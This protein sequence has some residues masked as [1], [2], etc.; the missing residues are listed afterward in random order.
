MKAAIYARVSTEDQTHNYS[1]PTQIEACQ[2]AAEELGYSIVRENTFIDDG[3]SGATLDRPN[4]ERL[5]TAIEQGSIQAVICYDTDRLS[6]KL[7]HL[8][9]LTEEWDRRNIATTINEFQAEVVKHVF[10]WFLQEDLSTREIAQRLVEKGIP[11]STGLR[12]WHRGTVAE[13]LKD[14]TYAGTMYHNKRHSKT[15]P[16]GRKRSFILRPEA[17]WIGVPV[18]DI[19]PKEWVDLAVAK[20]EQHKHRIRRKSEHQYLLSGMGILTCACGGAITGRAR[21]RKSGKYYRWYDCNNSHLAFWP[22]E[23]RC[24]VRDLNADLAD[25]A[26]WGKIRD[27]LLN[28]DLIV[29]E[30]QRRYERKDEDLNSLRE[31]LDFVGQRLAKIDE[32]RRNLAFMGR[33]AVFGASTLGIVTK[34]AKKLDAEEKALLQEKAEIE[35]K[36]KMYQIEE[37]DITRIDEFC[38]RVS[39]NLDGFTHEEKRQAVA[40]LTNK[41]VWDGETLHLHLTIP[42]EEVS[43]L[44]SSSM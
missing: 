24:Q 27:L 40:T 17:E 29:H 7:A 4:L 8:L 35:R 11:S 28:P 21:L 12:R 42:S 22:Q 39:E 5:R 31:H 23:Y 30:L 13:I 2:K 19:V 44:S 33:E 6:R 25:K 26:V 10:R 38:R 37:E 34:E 14:S 16:D 3:H 18:P 15:S 43:A 1:I 20:L 32:G 9:L 41:I 36:L